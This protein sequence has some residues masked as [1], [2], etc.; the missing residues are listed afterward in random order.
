M[1]VTGL[2]ALKLTGDITLQ[3]IPC[4][5]TY[6]HD[7]PD[8]AA[9]L[10]DAPEEKWLRLFPN[11]IEGTMQQQTEDDPENHFDDLTLTRVQRQNTSVTGRTYA[12]S[13]ESTNARLEAMIAGVPNP[14]TADL[15][16]GV[17]VSLFANNDPYID[18]GFR[19]RVY[20]KKK[21]LVQTMY[22]YGYVR[23]DGE[24]VYNGKLQ[25]PQLT[26]EVAASVHNKT[27]FTEVV[28]GSSA[29]A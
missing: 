10:K 18:A 24:K 13:L 4:D 16:N 11:I 3:A 23:A 29:G 21:G 6:R 8:E 12:L 9:S 26:L 22:F 28:A 7:N 5:E 14:L 27:I 25:R 19:L 17:E 2:E 1:V 15:T 20:D